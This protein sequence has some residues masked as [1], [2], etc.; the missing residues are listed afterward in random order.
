MTVDTFQHCFLGLQSLCLGF[1]FRRSRGFLLRLQ[2]H[3]HEKASQAP[4]E[5]WG[6]GAWGLAICALTGFP[7]VS[8]AVGTFGCT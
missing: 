3:L 1:S 4:T 5:S 2:R 6:P 8:D 7:H